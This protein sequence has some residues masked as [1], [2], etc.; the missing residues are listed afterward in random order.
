MFENQRDLLW[1]QSNTI[2]LGSLSSSHTQKTSTAVGIQLSQSSCKMGD[3]LPYCF[4]CDRRFVDTKILEQHLQG[5]CRHD[6][7]RCGRVFS[8]YASLQK[9]WK[10]SS[11][12]TVTYCDRCD[13]DFP[14]NELRKDH[15]RT[16]PSRHFV[17]K[18]AAWTTRLPSIYRIIIL[19]LESIM[20]HTAIS[21]T[22]T[23]RTP[24]T[25]ARYG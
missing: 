9:H 17:C 2:D 8:S 7:R 25:C 6:C 3:Y 11:Y 15:V 4:R 22:E 1:N 16:V 18:P 24:T 20:K 10:K 5:P 12:H 23:S 19:H 14:N 13:I 21:V